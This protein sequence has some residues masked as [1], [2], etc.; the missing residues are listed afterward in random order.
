MSFR[1][2]T[3]FYQI[4]GSQAE[5]T[6][7]AIIQMLLKTRLKLHLEADRGLYDEDVNTYLAGLLVSYI[8]P[9]YL[10]AISKILSQHDI[11]VYQAVAKAEDRV[12]VYRIYKVNAD[13]LLVTLGVF[14]RLWQEAKAELG[15]AKR[16]YAY[17]SLYQRRIYGKAT[18]VGEIQTKLAQRTERYLSILSGAR[19]DYLHFVEQVRSEELFAFHRHL[20]RLEMKLPLKAVQDEFLDAYSDWRKG[21]RDP[22]VRQRLLRLIHRLKELD[23]AFQPEPFLAELKDV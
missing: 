15:R 14:R 1:L 4:P 19:E 5:A 11:D 22:S 18:A 10:K 20:Q 8:D 3:P 12:H 2:D 16:Y 6:F 17:A 7:G 23:P 21:T 9:Q 13:D